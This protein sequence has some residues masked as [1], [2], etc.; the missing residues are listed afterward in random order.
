[1]SYI[2]EISTR[3]SNCAGLGFNM[4]SFGAEGGL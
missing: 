1:M 3:Y 2:E 4:G